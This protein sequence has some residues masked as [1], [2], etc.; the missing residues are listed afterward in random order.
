M[1]K[2]D[3][4]QK[5]SPGRILQE[6]SSKIFGKAYRKTRAQEPFLNSECRPANLFKKRLMHRF[7][8]VR[9]LKLFRTAFL[10]DSRESLPLI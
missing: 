5:Q 4:L 6:S 3:I 7:F 2:K 10:K 1:K 8:A 9:F